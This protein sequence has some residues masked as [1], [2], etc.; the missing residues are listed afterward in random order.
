MRALNS[1]AI[2]KLDA[3]I[4]EEKRQQGQS[5]KLAA[6]PNQAKYDAPQHQQEQN[7]KAT[8]AVAQT[9]NDLGA[10]EAAAAATL[11][12]A[13]RNM[14]LAEGRLGAG[15]PGD[16]AA[17]QADAAKNMQNA[18]DQLEKERQK[19][20]D[21]LQMQVRKQVIENL[22]EMLDR[23]KSVRGGTESAEHLP[24]ADRETIL[25]V[26][27]LAPPEL[28]IVRICDQTLDLINQ[29]QFSVALPPALSDIRVSMQSVA[30]RLGDGSADSSVVTDE[31]QIEHDLADLLETFKQLS[32]DPGP[33]SNCRGCKNNKNKLLAELK[34]LRMLQTRVDDRTTR[35]D[36]ERANDNPADPPSADT[37]S[38]INTLRDSQ[39]QLHQAAQKIH[40]EL[41]GS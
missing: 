17:Q 21:E 4:K 26:K 29:T 18:R 40:E 11:G 28:S 39:E 3:G 35:L 20:L 23:Q 15:Q 19:I 2:A 31:K 33:P 24:S 14:N 13:S 36:A 25:R 10:A 30:D 32:A 6:N 27:R 41:S 1:A 34:V 9:H 37:Q 16:A 38:R 22:Q 7:R 8:D 12:D 5:T